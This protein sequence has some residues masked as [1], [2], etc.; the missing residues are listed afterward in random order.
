MKKLFKEKIPDSGLQSLHIRQRFP[1][2]KYNGRGVWV[3]TLQPTPVS[4]EYQIKITHKP[5]KPPVVNVLAPKLA[6]EAP[7]LYPDGSLCLFYPKDF[8]WT[9][10]SLIAKTIIPWTA[11]WLY[12]YELWLKTGIWHGHSIEHKPHQLD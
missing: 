12:F 10:N 3:G 11:L 5:P 7:H 1:Q 9:K 4:P 2:F 8:S 6:E